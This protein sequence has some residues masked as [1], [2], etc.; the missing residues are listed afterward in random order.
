MFWR[1]EIDE[2][3]EGKGEEDIGGFLTDNRSGACLPGCLGA[4]CEVA[5]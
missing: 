3:K 5:Q 2:E 4:C 1:V